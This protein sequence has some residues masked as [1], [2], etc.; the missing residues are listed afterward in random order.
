MFAL[1]F[2]M[3]GSGFDLQL[4]AHSYRNQSKFKEESPAHSSP[5]A[6]G[7]LETQMPSWTIGSSS[8]IQSLT[9]V[10]PQPKPPQSSPPP[11]ALGCDVGATPWGSSAPDA[12]GGSWASSPPDAVGGVVAIMVHIRVK[13]GT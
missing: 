2:D 5:Q 8:L 12:L 1:I 13:K 10:A 4:D 7:S 3:H 9:V 11:D 6:M